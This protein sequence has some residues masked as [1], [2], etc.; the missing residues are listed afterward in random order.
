MARLFITIGREQGIRS[1]DIISEISKKAGIEANSI[2]GVKIFDTFTFVDVPRDGAE[3]VI[4][5]FHR[6]MIS[7]KSVKVTPARP[8]TDRDDR[9]NRGA[10]TPRGKQQ[11]G[12][13]KH[14]K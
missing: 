13:K 3:K 7:G 4:E 11:Y 1:G 8:R 6:K 9:P 14:H 12:T 10:R 2:Q 5:L